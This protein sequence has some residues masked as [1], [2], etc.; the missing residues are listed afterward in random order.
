MAKMFKAPKKGDDLVRT[1]GNHGRNNGL[2]RE[3]F[4][5][6]SQKTKT[7]MS[8]TPS[9]SSHRPSGAPPGPGPFTTTASKTQDLTEVLLECRCQLSTPPPPGH[10]TASG[11]ISYG[12]CLPA[13][14]ERFELLA[15]FELWT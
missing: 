10:V 2:G 7:K 8:P 12:I 1:D 5:W 13:K 14:P 6:N 11:N 3:P 9:Q 4:S 15:P